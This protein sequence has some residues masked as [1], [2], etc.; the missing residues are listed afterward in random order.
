MWEISGSGTPW[1]AAGSNTRQAQGDI[2]ESAPS[3]AKQPGE[4]HGSQPG[5][6]LLQC[7]DFRIVESHRYRFLC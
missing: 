2:M 1:A 7:P 6:A 3:A 4:Q 5:I